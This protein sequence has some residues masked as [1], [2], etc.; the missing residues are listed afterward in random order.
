MRIR[1]YWSDKIRL[2]IHQLVIKVPRIKASRALRTVAIALKLDLNQ[3]TL[4]Y[5]TVRACHQ[6]PINC[7]TD[8]DV[9]DTGAGV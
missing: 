4:V 5:A 6:D 9:E 8:G 1:C 2:E 3:S 7:L